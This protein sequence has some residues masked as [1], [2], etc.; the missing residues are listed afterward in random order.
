MLTRALAQ[1]GGVSPCGG[2]AGT[3]LFRRRG[4]G[5]LSRTGDHPGDFDLI[6]RFFHELWILTRGPMIE[7][8]MAWR[9]EAA[10]IVR[11]CG[12][13]AVRH[14]SWDADFPGLREG[15]EAPTLWPGHL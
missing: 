3:F 13:L 7:S 2:M 11:E 12:A 9:C 6:G 15:I 10:K 14:Q 4:A 1:D 8:R 5:H